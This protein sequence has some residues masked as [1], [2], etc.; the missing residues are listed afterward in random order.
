MTDSTSVDGLA[1]EVGPD[2]LEL[3]CVATSMTGKLPSDS[4]PIASTIHE[5]SMA[6]DPCRL[7]QKESSLGTRAIYSELL[8]LLPRQFVKCPLPPQAILLLHAARFARPMRGRRAVG[9]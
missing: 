3:T 8:D 5:M 7:L 1:G 9:S 6:N 4:R 2:A